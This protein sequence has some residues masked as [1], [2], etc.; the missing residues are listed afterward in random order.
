MLRIGATQRYVDPLAAGFNDL[1]ELSKTHEVVSRMKTQTW[2]RILTRYLPLY[3]PEIARFAGNSR[4]DWFLAMIERFPTPAS[5]PAFDREAFSAEVWPLHGLTA[6]LRALASEIDRLEA[7]ILAWHRADVTSRRLDAIPRIGP[8][9]AS[10]ISA[11]VP[12]A[13]LFRSGRQ[14]AAW[15]GLAPRAN[16]SG[17]K[18][19]LGGITKQG[20]SYLLLRSRGR[21][22]HH[23]MFHKLKNWKAV[24]ARYDS[25]KV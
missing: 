6:Q 25:A 12:D 16:N 21:P 11:A 19:R 22:R 13:S 20:D 7:Q 10:A 5:I 18:E 17:G 4:S 2:H 1:Q 23:A 14:F 9:T 8:I 24:T 15:F 3:F